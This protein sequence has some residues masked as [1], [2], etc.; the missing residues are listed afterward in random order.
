[1]ADFGLAR[2]VLDDEYTASEGTKYPVKWAAPEVINYNRFSTKSDVWSFGI[3]L[4]EI[5]SLGMKPYPGMDN[6]TVM[7]KVSSGYRMM[8]PPLAVHDLHDTMMDCWHS[9][10]DARPTFADLYERLASGNGAY[11]REEDLA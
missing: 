9:D 7:D 2:F 4:W 11:A 8:R 1:M 6:I 3:I 10:P 5:W